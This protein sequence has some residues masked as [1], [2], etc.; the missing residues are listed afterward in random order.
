MLGVLVGLAFAFVYSV[1][2]LVISLAAEG[3]MEG[4][5]GFS[6]FTLIELYFLAGIIG[7]G[8]VGFLWPWTVT[9]LG[10][11]IVGVIGAL[12]LSFGAALLVEQS[13][14]RRDYSS[15]LLAAVIYAVIVGVWAG[16]VL[17]PKPKA[18]D[19]IRGGPER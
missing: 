9:R 14:P 8:S 10:A 17:F 11:V 12:P 2:A 16:L 13:R 5:Y 7:G 6:V 15:A 4:E 3:S 19:T 1:L 18:A